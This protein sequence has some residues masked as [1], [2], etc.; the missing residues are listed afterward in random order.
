MRQ[1]T[2]FCVR[3]V[4]DL[5]PVWVLPCCVFSVRVSVCPACACF[6]CVSVCVCACVCACLCVSPVCRRKRPPCAR[7]KRSRVCRQHAHMCFN[8]CEWCQ[9]TRGRFERTH[10]EQGGHS[11]DRTSHFHRE[12]KQ[13]WA[14]LEHLN[15]MSG[16]CLIANF[17]LTMR[18]PRRVITCPREVHRK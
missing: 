14:F 12:N 1:K 2:S 7:S 8:M 17:L 10:G 15:P 5:Y 13:T 4:V 3:N 18:R 11:P 6:L 16:S 9:Y